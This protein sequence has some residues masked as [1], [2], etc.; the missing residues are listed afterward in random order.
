MHRSTVAILHNAVVYF[1]G[2]GGIPQFPLDEGE[3]KTSNVH[4][5]VVKIVKTREIRNEIDASRWGNY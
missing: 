4:S 3:L 2:R 1:F 5:E